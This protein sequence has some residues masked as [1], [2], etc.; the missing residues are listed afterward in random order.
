MTNVGKSG[1]ALLLGPSGSRPL[2][3]A[4]GDGSGIVNE[5]NTDLINETDR[6]SFS[7][8]DITTS[9]ETTFI[10]DFNSLEMSGTT[11]KEFGVYSSVASGVGL[12]W[13]REGFTG[14]EFDGTN[15]VQIQVIYKI[16]WGNKNGK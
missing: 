6:A 11:L 8:T 13:S 9:R 15:E 7:S 1:L 3:I 16:V 14:V 4:I 10:S 12:C 5:F 2:A